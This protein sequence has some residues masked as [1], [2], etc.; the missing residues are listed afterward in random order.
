MRCDGGRV[1]GC[2]PDPAVLKNAQLDHAAVMDIPNAIPFPDESFDVVYSDYVLE[3]VECPEAFLREVIRVLKPGGSFFFRTPNARHYVSVIARST[4]QWIH[5]RV[6]NRVRTLGPDAHA[7]Y[8]TYHRMNTRSTLQRLCAEIC[9]SHLE[10]IM[11]EGE[12]SYLVFNSLAFL[13]GV[14]YERIVNAT[15]WLSGMRVN[16][17]GRAIK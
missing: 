9:F 14:G 15:T 1:A 7:P 16:I 11:F 6:A 2:D 17:F 3:H 4:P 10:M 5:E 12:P 8:P 13:A